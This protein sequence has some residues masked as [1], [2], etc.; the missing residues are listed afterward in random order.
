MNPLSQMA[1]M[2]YEIAGFPF[3]DAISIGLL[4]E[5]IVKFAT[6]YTVEVGLSMNILLHF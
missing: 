5:F 6:N 1:L 3:F 4:K 2:P